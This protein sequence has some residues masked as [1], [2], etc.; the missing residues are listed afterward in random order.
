M[1]SWV[2]SLYL[3]SSLLTINTKSIF[4]NLKVAIIIFGALAIRKKKTSKVSKFVL[5]TQVPQN[6]EYIEIQWI[7]QMF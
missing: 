4:Q 6:F 7:K 5:G 2:L 3:Y 1:I